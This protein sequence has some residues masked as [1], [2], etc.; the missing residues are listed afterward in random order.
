MK[1]LSDASEYAV[2]AAIWLA[3]SPQT[4]QKVRDIAAGTRAAPGYLIKVLQALQKAGILSA[5]RGIRGGFVLVRDPQQL[6]VLEVINAVDPLERIACC[7]LGLEAHTGCLCAWHQHLD[8]A[9]AAAEAGL[10]R[11][12][13]G[14]LL[15]GADGIWPSKGLR[16]PRECDALAAGRHERKSNARGSSV[17]A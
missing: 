6:S 10:G 15:A 3:Q 5:Q 9:I 7:P 13:I 4:P 1:V 14:D 11:R 8:G 17:G 12:T 16:P 2:R